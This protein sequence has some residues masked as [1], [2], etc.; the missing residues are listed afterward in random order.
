MKPKKNKRPLSD[1]DTTIEL[2]IG[3]FYSADVPAGFELRIA[4]S[5]YI[6]EMLTPRLEWVA[7]GNTEITRDT[8]ISFIGEVEVYRIEADILESISENAA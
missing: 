3:D 8:L 1:L 5:A 4:R 6:A 7:M 2:N